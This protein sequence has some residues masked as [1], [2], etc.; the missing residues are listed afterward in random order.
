[1][2]IDIV[3]VDE[4]VNRLFGNVCFLTLLE[5]CFQSHILSLIDGE[6][7]EVK[8]GHDGINA[9][10]SPENIFRKDNFRIIFN[11]EFPR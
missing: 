5:F 2:G 8:I 6:V 11:E 7:V 9:G 3:L 1:M 4:K 10:K